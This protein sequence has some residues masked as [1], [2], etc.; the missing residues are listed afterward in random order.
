M[1]VF[2]Y[3][4]V[5]ID[6]P[7]YTEFFT[8][9]MKYCG[10][11]TPTL[12]L[13]NLTYEYIT[14]PN[15]TL[16]NPYKSCLFSSLIIFF[17]GGIIGVLISGV[18]VVIPAHYHGSIVGISLAFM[19]YSY[20]FIKETSLNCL[21]NTNNT[22]QEYAKL[23]PIIY[24]VGQFLHISGLAIAGGYGAMRKTPGL[25]IS[26]KAKFGMAIMGIGGV[27]AIIGGLMFVIIC[28][29]NLYQRKLNINKV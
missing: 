28:V 22:I 27:I 8:L 4:F 9:H 14:S 23:Q 15:K 25:E 24:A 2:I 3:W 12:I 11:I 1:R 7:I 10:G 19:G 13:F 5:H 6:D 18:N 29:K 17:S 21:L 16:N 26:T 20:Y